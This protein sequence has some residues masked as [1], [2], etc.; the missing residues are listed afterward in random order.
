VAERTSESEGDVSELY[1]IF[2]KT[3]GTYQ[4]ILYLC[5]RIKIRRT[6]MMTSKTTITPIQLHLLEMFKYCDSE[7]MMTDLKDCL[8][9]FYA[10][11][12]QNEADRLWDEGSLNAEAIEKILD[13][14]WRT[15]YETAK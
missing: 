3:F 1:Q 5:H 14:H 12:V 8:A 15:P 7:Q 10:K 2:A 6:V 4:I 11:Q 9:E 13:E